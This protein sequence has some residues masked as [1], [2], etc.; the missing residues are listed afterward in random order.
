VAAVIQTAAWGQSVPLVG[1]ATFNS[2]VAS[3]TSPSVNVG[4]PSSFTGLIQF[5]LTKLPTGTMA[6]NV[7]NA[8]L[9]LFLRVSTPGSINIYAALGAWNELTVNA[10]NAP[11][12]GPLIAGPIS[13]ST[14]SAFYSIPVTA[15]VQA[16]LNNPST[17]NGFLIQG[18]AG[19]F[20]LI[21]SKESGSTSHP[22]VLEIDLF[23]QSGPTGAVGPTGPT[24][25][26]GPAGAS[27]QGPAGVAGNAG[28]AGATG[29]SPSGPA[30]AAGAIGPT[31]AT[32]PLGSTGPTGPSGFV[33]AAGTTGPAGPTGPA[34]QAGANGAAGA[35]GATGNT[36]IVAGPTGAIGNTGLAG[37]AG[38]AGNQGPG[39]SQGLTGPTGATGAMGIQGVVGNAGNTGP[40][41]PTGPQGLI[42][43]SFNFQAGGAIATSVTEGQGQGAMANFTNSTY[44]VNDDPTCFTPSNPNLSQFPARSL[45]LPSAVAAG[46]GREITL[47]NTNVTASGCFVFVYPPAG[48]KI[49][50]LNEVIPGQTLAGLGPGGTPGPLN[51]LIVPFYARFVS[52]GTNWRGIDAQ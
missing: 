32:G 26:T 25:A 41:G 45:T 15:Q 16:W 29:A 21:D 50:Y 14:S 10:G 36:G 8:S 35:P 42:N 52:D 33:G 44:L 49:L 39:G 13:V 9:R 37:G 51:Q 34:G 3:G 5:D 24:G 31:G 23:G 11:S 4:G 22:A 7:S 46:A 27:P 17:N 38:P 30:G 43:N 12:V 6:G 48:E 40:V 19:G 20:V 18:A 28:P 1:D 47:I 2:T